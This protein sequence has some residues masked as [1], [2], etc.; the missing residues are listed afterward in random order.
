MG[1]SPPLLFFGAVIFIQMYSLAG[2]VFTA[3]SR[4]FRLLIIENTVG[5]LLLSATGSGFRN[6]YVVSPPPFCNVRLG[7]HTSFSTCRFTKKSTVKCFFFSFSLFFF[8]FSGES[9]ISDLLGSIAGEKGVG[10][11]GVGG[12]KFIFQLQCARLTRQ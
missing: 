3:W 6:S 2:G 9:I 7:F 10:G 8:I 12:A 4:Q 5:W 11:G 1:L